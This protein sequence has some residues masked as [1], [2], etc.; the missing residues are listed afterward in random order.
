MIKIDEEITVP[1]APARVWQVL[2]DPASVASCIAGAELQQINDD[3]SIDGVLTVKF[4]A[5][6]V[7]FRGTVALELDEAA[8]TGKIS[9]AG[10]D[11]QGATRF[12]ARADF[13]VMDD[14]PA[15]SRVTLQGDVELAGKLASIVES[16]ASAVIA[17]MKQDFAA[18]LIERCGECDAA[19][20]A[21]TEPP[22]AVP[23]TAGTD[24]QPTPQPVSRPTPAPAPVMKVHFTDVLRSWWQ[25]IIA[26]FGRRTTDQEQ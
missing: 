22:V 18:R 14:Q 10:K 15:G 13:A 1:Y 21:G 4:G 11:G 2:S 23:A 16:G 6:R 9:G 20:D 25:R 7:A 19:R 12:N 8:R 3:G 17:R 26:V 24:R 5:I